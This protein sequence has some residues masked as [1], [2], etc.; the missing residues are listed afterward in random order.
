MNMME[1]ICARRSIRDYTGDPVTEEQLA[2]IL[3]AANAAP[4]GMGQYDGVHL[5]IITNKAL[6]EKIDSVAAAMFGKPDAHV[7]MKQQVH[8]VNRGVVHQPVQFACLVHIPG[9]LVFDSGA[10]DGD[11]ATVCIFDLHAGGIDVKL[12]RNNFLFHNS[13][14]INLFLFSGPLGLDSGLLITP[15]RKCVS[16][17]L[18]KKTI[19]PNPSPIWKIWFGLYCFGA[20][21]RTRTGMVSRLILSQV[22]LPIPPHRRITYLLYTRAG[23]KS[24]P[25]GAS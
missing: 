9:N 24:S 1:T 12:T 2:M 21:G 5:T 15:F 3:R 22:R 20:G 17:N 8:R 16:S 11:H 19:N 7:S 18:L 10:V 25:P 13:V 14:S 23:K 4:V 6:L